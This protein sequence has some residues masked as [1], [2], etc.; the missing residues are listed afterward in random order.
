LKFAGGDRSVVEKKI[1]GVPVAGLA[2]R[3]FSVGDATD[4]NPAAFGFAGSAPEESEF[5][6]GAAAR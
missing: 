6:V 3:G 2:A 5:A 4:P 1:I